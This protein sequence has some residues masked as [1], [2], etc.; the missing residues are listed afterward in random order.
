MVEKMS[1]LILQ[2]EIDKA[3]KELGGGAT[4]NKRENMRIKAQQDKMKRRK[5]RQEEAAAAAAA[6]EAAKLA[7]KKRPAEA[8]KEPPAKE[9]KGDGSQDW[10]LDPAN[11]NAYDFCRH[12][13]IIKLSGKKTD[14]CP[15]EIE[16][17]AFDETDEKGEGWNLTPAQIAKLVEFGFIVD[18]E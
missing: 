16:D 18:D 2:D 1:H 5:E 14:I 6:K 9:A 7:G 4:F 3:R 13:K 10:I 11:K 15:A 12:H 17:G 8:K